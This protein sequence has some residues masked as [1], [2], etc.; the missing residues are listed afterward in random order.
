MIGRPVTVRDGQRG[1]TAGVAVELGQHDAGE[2]DAVLERLG[3]GDRVLADHRVDDEQDLVGLDRVADVGGLLHQLGVD[4]EPAGGVDDDDV[5]LRVALACSIDAVGATVD[6][7]ADAVAGLRAR[8]P[9]TPA[10]SPTTCSWVT[11]LGRCRSAATS[12]GVW[13]WPLSQQRE[14]A[15]QRGLAGALQAG[16]HDHG[17]RVLGEPRAGGSRRRGSRRAPR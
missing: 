4:A 3:G 10:R 2:V 14:L 15:G 7:V 9:A 13:P 5:V 6:R 16:E 17:R 1:A 12:S 8:T 11:A